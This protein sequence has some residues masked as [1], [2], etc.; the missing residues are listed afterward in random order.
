MPNRITEKAQKTQKHKKPSVSKKAQKTLSN[1]L[2]FQLCFL[3]KQVVSHIVTTVCI[4]HIALFI[5]NNTIH[6]HQ[7]IVIVISAL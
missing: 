5:Y 3:P 6:E 4:I 2:P 7:L 1:A